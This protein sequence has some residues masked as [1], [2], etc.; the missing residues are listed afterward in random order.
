MQ[1]PVRFY[2]YNDQEPVPVLGNRILAELKIELIA[3]L[4]PALNF[5]MFDALTV[6]RIDLRQVF[7]DLLCRFL[8]QF[9]IRTGL[10]VVKFPI[11]P[12]VAH[13]FQFEDLAGNVCHAAQGEIVPDVIQIRAVPSVLLV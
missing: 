11:L 7:H 3:L 10:F 6:L 9:R 2:P 1:L 4:H 13:V 12:G 5:Q 8:G